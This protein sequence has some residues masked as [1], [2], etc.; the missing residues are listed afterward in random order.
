MSFKKLLTAALLSLLCST[1]S[2]ATPSFKKV[3]I[4]VLENTNYSD[5]VS[6][7]FLNSL[8]KQ[9]SLLTNFLAETHP[10]QGNYI[11]MTSGDLMG[12]RNDKN[13]DIDTK[14]IGDLLEARGLNW[15]VYADG[16]PGNCFTG[17]SQGRYVRKHNPFISYTNVNQNI[18]RCN[19]HIFNSKVL[20]NDIKTNN[21]PAYSFYAPD[22]DNDGHDTG[23]K[24]ADKWLAQK[25]G[26]LLK[27]PAFMKD[28]LLI[29]TFDESGL[30]SPTNH[31]ATYFIGDSVSAGKQSSTR[32]SFYSMLK[33]IESAFNLGTLG[34]KD[35]SATEIA[36]IFN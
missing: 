20:D 1:V 15:K 26:P 31:I 34:K 19:D 7:P 27:N 13:I 32:Y 16:Y 28:M 36:D 9:G 12:V 2:Y 4:V 21:L 35:E 14:H 25:F 6:Q 10:S 33:T 8:S 29:I 17:S 3:M 22:L 5:A 23:V 24:F 11:A 30:L 18:K